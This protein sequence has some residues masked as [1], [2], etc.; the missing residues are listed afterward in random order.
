MKQDCFRHL[1]QG[2][3]QVLS[4]LILCSCLFVWPQFLVYVSHVDIQCIKHHELFAEHLHQKWT[5]SSIQLITAAVAMLATALGPT[6][7]PSM[8]A[9]PVP[10]IRLTPPQS[11]E[12]LRAGVMTRFVYDRRAF[13]TPARRLPRISGQTQ[14]VRCLT[15]SV[16][17]ALAA[18]VFHALDQRRDRTPGHHAR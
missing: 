4:V 14:A 9:Q 10:I 12:Q 15:P 16:V 11:P 6:W 18:N 1:L 13:V 17:D 5:T 3:V 2:G 7:D 8:V